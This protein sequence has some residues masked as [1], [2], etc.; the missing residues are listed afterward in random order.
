MILINLL[1]F[2]NVII[3]KIMVLRIFEN[4]LRVIALKTIYY[5]TMI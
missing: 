5:Y 1:S 3:I 4:T 2:K